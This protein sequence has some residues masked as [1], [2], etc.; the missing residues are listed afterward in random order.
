MKRQRI[1]KLRIGEISLVGE[2]DNPSAD[3]LI[4]KRRER[5]GVDFAIIKD[6]LAEVREG[7]LAIVKSLSEGGTPM[8]IEQL[9]EKLDQIEKSLTTVQGENATLKTTVEALTKERDEALAAVEKAKKEKKVPASAQADGGADDPDADDEVMKNLPAELRA[10]IE[11][12]RAEVKELRE[13]I[14]KERDEREELAEVEKV[15]ATGLTTPDTYGKLIHRVRKGKSTSED[16]DKLIELIVKSAALAKGGEKLFT[17]IG[18][19]TGADAAG[20]DAQA[21]L[22]E[23]I[24]GIQ[25]AKP[26]LTREQAYQEA[27]EANPALYDEIRKAKPVAA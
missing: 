6:R 15:K 7:A 22:D 23:A 27:I 26:S 25:K 10:S 1:T 16:A 11:K 19:A 20:A 24:V 4:L 9:T 14:A 5:V 2:G 8:D 18:K 21:Q 12:D 13:S 17:T 3:V